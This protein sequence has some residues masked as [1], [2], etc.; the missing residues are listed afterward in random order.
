LAPALNPTL[1]PRSKEVSNGKVVP[2]PGPNPHGLV[3]VSATG[4]SWASEMS[5]R[6]TGTLG[7]ENVGKIK[8]S[9]AVD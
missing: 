9:V 4:D 7:L 5:N 6:S 3:R 2:P 1:R 8:P